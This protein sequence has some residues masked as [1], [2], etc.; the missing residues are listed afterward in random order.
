MNKRYQNPYDKI[1]HFKRSYKELADMAVWEVQ[2][3]IADNTKYAM[4]G[5]KN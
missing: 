2:S 4:S 5:K 1:M 3:G